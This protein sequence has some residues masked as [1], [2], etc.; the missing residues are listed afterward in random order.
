M[1]LLRN[2]ILSRM[3]MSLFLMSAFIHPVREVYAAAGKILKEF[4]PDVSPI[5]KDLAMKLLNGH[6]PHPYVPAVHVGSCKTEGHDLPQ[7]LYRRWS[8]KP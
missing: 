6:V 5:D 7:P 1:Y 4:P 3:G 2:I 8:L